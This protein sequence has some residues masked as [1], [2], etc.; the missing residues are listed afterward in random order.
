MPSG[1]R[2]STVLRAATQPLRDLERERAK[3]AAPD[4]RKMRSR[5]EILESRARNVTKLAAK[6]EITERVKA[7]E[8]LE[9]IRGELDS[10]G[11][12]AIPRLL[13]DDA[14]P[15]ALAGLLSKHGSIAVLAAE[16]AFV[17]NITGRYSDGRANL[18]VVCAAYSGEATTI[19]RRGHDPE[20][21][22][23]PLLTIALVVQPHVV[24]ALIAHPVARAQGL[25]AR[26]AYALPETR[27]GTRRVNAPRVSRARS[28]AWAAVVRRVAKTTDRTDKTPSEA[29]SVSSVRTFDGSKINLASSA[30][31]LLDE[32]QEQMEPR[33]GPAGDLRSIADWAGRHHG[34]VAR[35]AGL[36]HLCEHEPTEPIAEATMR[37]ALRI[38]EYLLAHG[39]A[40]LSGPD[41]P[42]RRALRW[43]EKRGESTVSVRDLHR[44][45]VGSQRAVEHADQLA[46]TLE[47]L[48]AL[49]LIPADNPRP[50]R[51]M[52]PKYSV[53]P[54]LLSGHDERAE[55]LDPANGDL[56]GLPAESGSDG[57]GEPGI[58]GAVWNGREEVA[59]DDEEA[60]LERAPRMIGG[61][62]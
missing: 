44:G 54:S 8:E 22:D 13:A 47:A 32:L 33:L 25:V 51:P 57:S 48:G 23:R 5:I 6:D 28:E 15:E 4:V 14:T 39:I 2:K 7:Q 24:E 52:S 46:R 34:R 56:G 27:L 10:I 41:D 11:Q 37:A 9:R 17:D 19:D 43:L 49:R 12:P 31:R 40:A 38:G 53:N 50:G 26:F 60:Q 29:S 30:G 35:I 18:H 62:G 3:L 36:L 16:S 1:D 61:E 42:T 21:L 20:R 55:R 45:P 59:T 58:G